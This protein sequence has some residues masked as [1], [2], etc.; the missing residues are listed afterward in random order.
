MLRSDREVYKGLKFFLFCF[1]LLVCLRQ[2]LPMQ[3]F[4][5]DRVAVNSLGI[6]SWPRIHIDLPDSASRVL[7]LEVCIMMPGW[8]LDYGSNDLFWPWVGREDE[9]VSQAGGES[10]CR[11]CWPETLRRQRQLQR[12][13]LNQVREEDCMAT[14]RR[15]CVFLHPAREGRHSLWLCEQSQGGCRQGVTVLWRKGTRD[16]K[17]SHLFA[18]I[19]K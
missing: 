7:R 12:Q 2:R 3:F 14:E 15:G 1:C 13:M 9:A 19:K 4:E 11:A 18:S 8:G 16:C 6:P 17:F 5:L 10:G